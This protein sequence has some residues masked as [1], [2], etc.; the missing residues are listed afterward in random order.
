MMLK[1]FSFIKIYVKNHNWARQFNMLCL[2]KA[3]KTRQQLGELTPTFEM[4]GEILDS[5][6]SIHLLSTSTFEMSGEILDSSASIHLLITSYSC[7]Q[8]VPFC[9]HSVS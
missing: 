7:S 8:H 4:S 5:S 9:F 3:S 6:A 2:G 1:V